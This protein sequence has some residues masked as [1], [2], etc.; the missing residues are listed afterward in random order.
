VKH[1]TK[2]ELIAAFDK[3]RGFSVRKSVNF[4]LSRL[5]KDKKHSLEEEIVDALTF[6]E[7]IGALLG[8]QSLA[9]AAEDAVSESVDH[10]LASLS[11]ILDNGA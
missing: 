9:E 8:A 3:G 6:E 5:Y 1:Y 10:S 2:K 11:D 4:C 7:L